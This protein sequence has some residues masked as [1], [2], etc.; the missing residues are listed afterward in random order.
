MAY[1]L[2][3]PK[4]ITDLIYELRDWPPR[5]PGRTSC[6]LPDFDAFWQRHQ[7][8]SHFEYDILKRSQT[9]NRIFY[10]DGIPR[11]PRRFEKAEWAD[12]IKRNV[13]PNH[14][15]VD[16]DEY[17]EWV[18]RGGGF[19]LFKEGWV[20]FSEGQ[21]TCGWVEK[22]DGWFQEEQWEMRVV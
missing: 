4:N 19:E 13:Y 20:R 14:S 15:E 12:L 8:L 9:L 6:N 2:G 16:W 1:A 3:F 11:G 5:R 17:V 10:N 21:S 7:F 18:S 22:F